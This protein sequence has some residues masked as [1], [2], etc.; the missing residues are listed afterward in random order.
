MGKPI[1]QETWDEIGVLITSH[2]RQQK[3]WDQ[4]FAS[5]AG[6]PH[7]MVLGYD[8]DNM[9]GIPLENYMP[10]VKQTFLTDRPAGKL[11]HFRGE[12]EQLKIGGKLLAK[13][14]YEYFYKSAAD[15]CCYRWRNIPYLHKTL[16]KFDL[17]ICGTTQM[18]GKVSALNKVMELWQESLRSGGAEL[19]VYSQ[20][21]AFDL[22]VRYEKAPFW[23]TLLGLVHVQGECALNQGTNVMRT[24]I[25]GQKWGEENTHRDL[26]PRR[27]EHYKATGLI[28]PNED[29]IQAFKKE[30]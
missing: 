11:G 24:W 4:A 12:L 29:S 6:Y 23:N 26:T 19:Y 13:Y 8:D 17:L 21:R 25:G 1:P 5:W 27:L 2:P 9:D 7:F 30:R 15:N 16:K 28:F 14:G 10:P 20:I 3:F 18:F 22:N